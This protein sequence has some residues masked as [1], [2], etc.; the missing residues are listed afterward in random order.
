[1]KFLK[2]TIFAAIGSLSFCA[3]AQNQKDVVSS[4]SIKNNWYV[5]VLALI[6]S[7]SFFLIARTK[8]KKNREL[9][10]ARHNKKLDMQDEEF[11]YRNK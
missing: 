10:E 9:I 7:I 5:I 4:I 6:F 2:N 11:F 3:F 8:Q 1:M